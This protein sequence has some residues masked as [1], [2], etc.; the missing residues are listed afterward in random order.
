MNGMKKVVQ[1]GAA[2]ALLALVFGARVVNA[3]EHGGGGEHGG[4]HESGIPE[5]PNLLDYLRA[6]FTKIG[7]QDDIVGHGLLGLNFMD[8]ANIFFAFLV[9]IVLSIIAIRLSRKLEWIPKGFQSLAELFVNG[10]QNYFV[11]IMGEKD[12]RIFTPFVG[13]LFLYILCMNYMGLIPFI[14][15]PIAMNIN[16]P[17]SM[18]LCVFF[19]VQYHGIKQAGIKKYAKHF[20]GERAGIPVLDQFLMGLNLLLHILGEFV[21]PFSLTLRLFNNITAEDAVMA[22]LV[23]LMGFLPV[24]LPILPVQ[25]I[26]FP[27]ALLFGLIQALVFATLSSIYISLMSAHE[28]HGHEEYEHGH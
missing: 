26:F 15:S 16:V 14:K 6:A 1:S 3:A 13:T 28:E 7:M 20:L 8:I 18:A 25:A 11:G 4:G 12:G 21:K 23:L 27:L 2:A 17:L 9:I 19:L 5:L 22:S 24:Y 10:M